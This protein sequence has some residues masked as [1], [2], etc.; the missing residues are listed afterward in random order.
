MENIGN[1]PKGTTELKATTAAIEADTTKID[2]VAA[3][4]LTGVSNSLAYRVGEIERHLHNTEKWFGL[5][6]VASGETHVA[7]R[8]ACLIQP[9]V[10]TAGNNDFGAWVQILGSGDTPVTSGAVK[11][12]GHRVI[13]TDTNSTNP[14]IVQVVAGESAD[15]A[16]NIAAELFTE[17]PYISA[18]NNNDSGITDIMTRRFPVGTKVWARCCCIGSNGSTMD[19]YFGLHEYE[20]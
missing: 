17:A 9:F 10:I 6:A 19:F 18:T 16:A 15:I 12:D 3:N 20:G 5:A 1:D 2:D 11:F 14:Y 7:D 8:L 13:T 4:G